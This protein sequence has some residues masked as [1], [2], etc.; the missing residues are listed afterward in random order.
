MSTPQATD[1]SSAMALILSAVVRD[2]GVPLSRLATLQKIP[3]TLRNVRVLKRIPL[4]S[5]PG[6]GAAV[7]RAEDALRG[8]GRI[9][10][11]YSGTE[12]LLRVLVEGPDA[13]EVGAVGDAVE[14]AVR[15]ELGG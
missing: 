11:R 14:A 2:S 10:L 4:E 8:R 15:A 6:I 12:P 3:Q 5:C 1:S 7:E 13:A 9:F